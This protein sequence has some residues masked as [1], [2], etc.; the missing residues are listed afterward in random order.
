MTTVNHPESDS[1]PAPLLGAIFLSPTPSVI[2][3]LPPSVWH[4]SCKISC[5]CWDATSHYQPP[6]VFI[7]TMAEHIQTPCPTCHV[8]KFHSIGSI[9]FTL[10]SLPPNQKTLKWHGRYGRM[11]AFRLRIWWLKTSNPWDLCFWGKKW[12]GSPEGRSKCQRPVLE[13]CQ[14]LPGAKD[15][16]S[17][18]KRSLGFF[19]GWPLSSHKLLTL[20]FPRGN[21]TTIPWLIIMFPVKLVIW[22]WVQTS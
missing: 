10:G 15:G 13:H 6:W 17:H 18:K 1:W 22:P 4:I 14:E 5:N 16:K 11:A 7:A 12:H 3:A 9:G 8:V 21:K 19:S 20:F 2:P